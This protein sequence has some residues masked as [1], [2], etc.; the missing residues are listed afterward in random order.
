MFSG[1]GQRVR[2]AHDVCGA[3]TGDQA[4]G[5][6]ARRGL[7]RGMRCPGN[8]C[9]LLACGVVVGDEA[10]ALDLSELLT[11]WDTP[12]LLVGDQLGERGVPP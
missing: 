4:L 1:G 9:R 7:A 10:L 3:G 8:V 2:A 12:A 11:H 6:R 5:D